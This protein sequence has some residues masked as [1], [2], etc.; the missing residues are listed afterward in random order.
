MLNQTLSRSLAIV[1]ALSV[2]P[3]CG[4][5]SEPTASGGA[6]HSGGSS[7]AAGSTAG[8]G[9]STGGSAGSGGNAGV[10]GTGG[11]GGEAGAV[12]DVE[13]WSPSSGL[14]P[15]YFRQPDDLFRVH[16]TH[17]RLY[18]RDT[19]IDWIKTR[20]EGPL[21]GPWGNLEWMASSMSELSPTGS[22]ATSNVGGWFGTKSEAIAFL[23]LIEQDPTYLAWAVEWAKALASAAVP[24]SDGELRSR[25]QRLAVVYDWL[26]GLMDGADRTQIRDG[27]IAHVEALRDWDYLA[28]PGYIGGHERRG[29]AIFAMGLLALYGDYPEAEDLLSQCRTHLVDGFYPTQ[30][31]IGV[32]GGYHMG[33]AYSSSYLNF[34]LPYLVWTVGT[35]DVLMDD[36]MGA[37]A[38]WYLYGL[39]GDDR[40]PAAGD[41]FSIDPGLGLKSVIYAS[42]P[43][44]D[45]HARWLLQEKMVEVDQ[46]LLQM[47]MLDENVSAAAPEPLPKG[48]HFRRAGLVVARDAWD[49]T[50]THFTFKSGSFFS[51]N[52][53]HRDENTFTLHYKSPLALDSGYYDS[54]GSEHWRNYFTRTIAH[55]GIT[56]FD[57]TQQMTLYGSEVSNDGGQ[58][59]KDEARTLSDIQPGGQSSLDGIVR[60]ENR[61]PFTYAW[62]DATKAY[63]PDRVTL[64]QREV[65]YLRQT[66]REHPVIVILDRVGAQSASFEKKFHLHTVDQPTLNGNLAV[67]SGDG[68]RLTSMT[69]LP[70]DAQLALVGGAGAEFLVNGTNYPLDPNGGEGAAESKGIEPG[71]WR[72]EVSPGQ[73]HETDL[74]LHVLFVDDDT[75]AMVQPADARLVSGAA[76]VGVQV[77]GWTVVFPNGSAGATEMSYS[78]AAGGSSHHLVVGLPPGQDVSYFDGATSGQVQTG[79]GGC[80]MFDLDA[81][82]GTT[83]TVD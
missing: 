31:W 51:I 41:A 67:A 47:V 48:K 2:L 35:N 37:A 21:A 15:G 32:D 9:G 18:F 24:T 33:W 71:A 83:V 26:H 40:F 59:F 3:G 20:A 62:G 72:V 52:H 69:L 45:P 77:A 16:P 30:S 6:G 22:E 64:A 55:N 60:F 8:T 5:E 39:Q 49:E 50:T 56:V 7:G 29:Y 76:A 19:D 27:L 25:I 10:G 57:P 12:F 4:D 1:I 80:A 65:V 23:A 78:T 54:Y 43:T 46:P 28:D 34:D 36:W 11:N 81:A 38:Q 74:F 53:H 14:K 66:E 70:S 75:A 63:D 17:P 61:E 79:D 13:G 42:G 73:S 44:S 68:S 58:V 82:A